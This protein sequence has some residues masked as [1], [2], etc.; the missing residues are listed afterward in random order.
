M[1]EVGQVKAAVIVCGELVGHIEHDLVRVPP[2]H[3]GVRHGPP[4]PEHLLVTR[5]QFI[6]LEAGVRVDRQVTDLVLGHVDVD[7]LAVGETAS[8][9]DHSDHLVPVDL[10]GVLLLLLQQFLSVLV[11]L[12]GGLGALDHL[13]GWGW[14]LHSVLLDVLILH[15]NAGEE[16]STGFRSFISFDNLCLSGCGIWWLGLFVGIVDDLEL[17]HLNI[18]ALAIGRATSW[19]LLLSHTILL[20]LL[21]LSFFLIFDF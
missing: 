19:L 12:R 2:R 10:D 14:L 11:G 18:V 9:V 20:L 8:G 5:D 16:E 4:D 6:E 13:L 3:E 1:L 15:V 17:V 7:A 21:H